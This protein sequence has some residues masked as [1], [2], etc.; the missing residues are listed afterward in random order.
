MLSKYIEVCNVTSY[1][2]PTMSSLREINQPSQ[3]ATT[4]NSRHIDHE[5]TTETSPK[6][7]SK[8]PE[9]MRIIQ[10]APVYALNKVR[11]QGQFINCA[12]E[13]KC[14]W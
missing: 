8:D 11:I 3:L 9:K 12:A 1:V 14:N 2:T 13:V 10:H 4:L 5:L 7:V 6:H